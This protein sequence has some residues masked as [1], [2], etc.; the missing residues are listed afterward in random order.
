MPDTL[1][2]HR[3]P[4]LSLQAVWNRLA[5]ATD[6]YFQPC[7][8]VLQALPADRTRL[9]MPHGSRMDRAEVM[10]MVEVIGASERGAHLSHTRVVG[11]SPLHGDEVASHGDPRRPAALLQ[12]HIPDA[13]RNLQVAHA[14]LRGKAQQ[15]ATDVGVDEALLVAR[16]VRIAVCTALVVH[17][18]GPDVDDNVCREYFHT[19]GGPCS[20]CCTAAGLSPSQKMQL[21]GSSEIEGAA[22]FTPEPFHRQP[23]VLQQSG[24]WADKPFVK[25]SMRSMATSMQPAKPMHS[26]WRAACRC[27]STITYEPSPRVFALKHILIQGQA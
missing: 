15:L 7:I 19:Q 1:A 12:Q 26:I 2:M 20:T 18:S 5:T 8:S 10:S 25:R 22:S 3:L 6:N 23:A 13:V 4:C 11:V 14:A 17:V 27:R 16:Q 21:L 24:K 9:T